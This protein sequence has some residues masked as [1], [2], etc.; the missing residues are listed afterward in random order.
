MHH[1]CSHHIGCNTLAAP[2]CPTQTEQRYAELI[3]LGIKVQLVCIG[4]K[5][6]TYFKRRPE[7]TIASAYTLDAVFLYGLVFLYTCSVVV[8]LLLLL[9]REVVCAFTGLLL[10]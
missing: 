5:G 4:K 8:F 7:Y 9:T 3:A 6:S 2:Q 10:V 1:R